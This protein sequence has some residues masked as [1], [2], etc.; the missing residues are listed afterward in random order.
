MDWREF[1]KL[2][3]NFMHILRSKMLRRRPALPCW[4][5]PV[6]EAIESLIRRDWNVV[7]FGSG[8]RR[9]GSPLRLRNVSNLTLR[10]TTRRAFYDLRD[11]ADCS[12]D[13][14]VVD[15]YCRFGCIEA[16]LPKLKAVSL[17]ATCADAIAA[18]TGR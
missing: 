7:E 14:A 1:K 16:V 17:S 4:P 13:F 2:P 12:F 18:S 9:C 11:F 5:F 8:S 10:L 15:R 6:K 3:Q